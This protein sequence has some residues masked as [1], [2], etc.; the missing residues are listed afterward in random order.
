[1]CTYINRLG[2][3][4]K[5]YLT[6]ADVAAFPDEFNKFQA[7]R[8]ENASC[9]VSTNYLTDWI[10]CIIAFVFTGTKRC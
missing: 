1:M 3:I 2:V 9:W 4:A 5:L 7:M 8:H 6:M 10:K